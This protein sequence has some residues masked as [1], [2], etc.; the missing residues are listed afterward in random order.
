MRFRLRTLLIL[1]AVMPP[2][3]WFGWTKYSVWKAE[4]ER[5]AALSKQNLVAPQV[6]VPIIVTETR[7]SPQ[8][9]VLPPGTQISTVPGPVPQM[10]LPPGTQIST[11]PGPPTPAPKPALPPTRLIPSP[12]R[13]L[14]GSR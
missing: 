12:D 10:V 6:Q 13:K 1:L 14:S 3:L 8:T 2:L 4:R 9:M 7:S 5:R 11:V